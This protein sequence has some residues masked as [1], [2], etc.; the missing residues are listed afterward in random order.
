MACHV[1]AD[2]ILRDPKSLIQ[3]APQFLKPLPRLKPHNPQT[4][5]PAFLFYN[6]TL[7]SKEKP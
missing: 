1:S 7:L 5:G 2:M 3:N 4:Q 6:L